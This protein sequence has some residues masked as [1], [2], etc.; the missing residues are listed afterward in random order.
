MQSSFETASPDRTR[1]PP[2]DSSS[3]SGAGAASRLRKGLGPLIAAAVV[4]ASALPGLVALPPL[5]RDESR[6]AQSTAQML[7]SGDFVDIRYRDKARDKKP[8]GI[9]WLQALSV[10]LV[11]SVERR[12]I[13]AYRIPSLG[14]AMLA[15]AAC[16]WGATRF[17]GAQGGMI[18]GLV[19][20]ASFLLS[21]EAFIAKTD[22]ALCAGVTLSMAALSRLYSAR[23]APAPRDAARRPGSIADGDERQAAALFWIG[24]A[25]AILV[26]GPIGPMIAGLAIA[27]LWAV[28]RHMSRDRSAGQGLQRAQTGWRAQP[29]WIGRLQW[30][31]GLIFLALAV[32]PWAVA[33][34][35]TTDGRFW[36][37]A[38]GGDLAPKLTGGQ[39]THGMAPGYHLL[40]SPL[41]LFPASL[42]L[43]AALSYGWRRRRE[44]FVRFALAWLVP[45]WLVFEAAPTR[46][47]HYTLPLYGAI[48]WLAAGALE[49]GRAGVRI[50]PWSRGLG[51]ALSMTAG[52]GLAALALVLSARFGGAGASVW[53]W[54]GAGASLAC[55][56]AGVIV[57]LRGLARPGVL[58]VLALGVVDHAILTGGLAPRLD[59]L[60][61]SARS[62]A[63]LQHAGLDPRQGLAQGPVAVAGYAEPSL[64]FA[65]GT[66]T[67]LDDGTDAADAL[68]DGQ[69]ALVE[70]GQAPAFLKALKADRIAAQ[71]LGT[72]RGFDYSDHKPVAL[73]LWRA[74]PAPAP[75]GPPNAVAGAAG[76]ASPKPR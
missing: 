22:A 63:L 30:G 68:T 56:G 7:E 21:S 13:W 54:L 15:A 53:A 5:D 59:S 39:E 60:W 44:V 41:L 70:A 40:L 29:S 51:A 45:S 25:L 34:T 37:S 73:T 9:N 52:V 74:E 10:E 24:Q 20:G 55:G 47:A 66:E 31:W 69:P 28:D 76:A 43:P 38:V 49:E 4:A 65:L 12:E 6:F 71:A 72:V 58:A 42:L 57:A 48:A 3:G 14:C 16:A 1:A 23:M 17:V 75:A 35:V 19:L 8:V 62:A 61:P 33:I 26:K 2:A 64:V 67:E 18:A 11:S 27:T 46:L 50:G 32:G 36:S